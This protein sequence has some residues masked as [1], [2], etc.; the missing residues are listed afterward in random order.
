MKKIAILSSIFIGALVWAQ[1][2]KFE[3]GKFATILAK[4]KK[5]KSWSL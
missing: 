4:A 5:K 2:I 3:E 1:G